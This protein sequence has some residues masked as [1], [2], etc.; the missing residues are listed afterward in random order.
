MEVD[1]RRNY[2]SYRG[3]GYLAQNY[4]NQRRIGQ[5]KEDR[6]WG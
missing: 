2:Y 6:I 5:R 1:R 3:F 4:K